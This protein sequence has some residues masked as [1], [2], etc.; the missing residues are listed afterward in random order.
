MRILQTI[1][2]LLLAPL[3]SW[4]QEKPKLLEK[5]EKKPGEIIIPYEK[6]QLPN[7]L[8][9]MVHEDHSNPMIHVEITY[10]VGS[11]REV[12]DRTG[13]AHFFEH[14]MFQGS[15]NVRDEEHFKIVSSAGG[16]MNGTT[17][18]D[19][20][21]YFET[22]PSNYLETAIWLEA[23]RMGF[24]LDSVTQKKF[25]VQRAT[26]KNEKGQ[27]VENRPYGM[28]EEIKNQ[29]LYPAGHPYSWTTIGYTEDLDRATVEDMRNFFLRW[30]GPNNAILVVSGDAKPEEVVK[31][32]EKY[33][34][35]IPKCPP[36]AKMKLDQV[37]LPE[38]VYAYY[39]DKIF[40]PVTLI[41]YPSAPAYHPDEPALDILAYIMGTG[42]SSFFYK[43]L[44]KTENALQA[45]A[46]NFS[47]ELAGEFGIQVAMFPPFQTVMLDS[48]N[49]WLNNAWADFEANG[50]T[51]EKL[52]MAKNSYESQFIN[53]MES[54]QSKAF[55]LTNW[56]LFANRSMNLNDEINRYRNVK[57]EDVMRVYNRYIKKKGAAWVTF[58][59]KGSDEGD[60][61]KASKTTDL[62]PVEIPNEYKNLSYRKPVDNF[63][64]SVHPTPG[65]AQTVVIPNI[66]EQ[67]FD[68]GIRIMGSQTT[69]VPT[70]TFLI[71]IK[72]GIGHEMK[73][74][75][76]AG[77]VSLFTSLMDEG[78]Q[79]K[80]A[81]QFSTELERLGSSINVSAGNDAV[82]VQVFSQLKNLDATLALLEEK[83]F[84][85]N[86]SN[87]DLKRIKKQIIESL[88]NQDGNSS[89][90]AEIIFDK[91]LF[92][93]N[94]LEGLN[95]TPKTIKNVTLEDIQKFYQDYFSPSVTE[96]CIAGDI[97][98][99]QALAKLAFLKKW[100]VKPVELPKPGEYF[101]TENTTIYFYDQ[102]ESPQSEI[103]VGCLGVPFN[104]TGNFLKANIMN[105]QLGGNFNS[106][107]N[108]NIRED[109][110]YTYGIR[111]GF[112]GDSHFGYFNI[113][114]GV[115]GEA[116]DSALTEIFK[117]L[118]NYRDNGVTNEEVEF[119][120]N[121]ML[122]SRSLR[123]ET[124]G[125]KVGY[126]YT[127][128]K[129]NLQPVYLKEQEEVISRISRDELNT[130]AKRLLPYEKMAVVIVGDKATLLKRVEA[131]KL[132]PVKNV[133]D[134]QNPP[135]NMKNRIKW[136]PNKD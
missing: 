109:K 59:P 112:N 25:E 133:K 4:A 26:V 23:D 86:F 96:I 36:V 69:E 20:T 68:N 58:L 131:L 62:T 43:H 134:Y 114:A 47:S 80:S 52:N 126:L 117:E 78:T 83:M 121:S 91:V 42:K 64:R 77:L 100:S 75:E 9:I 120:K 70:V 107:L 35:S 108:Q 45:T 76:K 99:E 28:F 103:R 129:Y 60:K 127:L 97:S 73:N 51:D 119:T 66:W 32:A 53:G 33:F 11:A 57:K 113:S 102:P 21:N 31:M 56:W 94:T 110:G 116:T 46:F 71:N 65:K 5:V 72:G 85:P 104:A 18:R 3:V 37:T 136:N 63:D 30:Y 130:I 17:N 122:N 39:N 135:L 10:H 49:V 115:K 2:F 90:I 48:V 105:F 50:L 93:N 118:K 92:G 89:Q 27:N 125:Q 19:R 22:L 98:Q 124:N 24:L 34:G 40:I 61:A 101:E 128:L 123:Y 44:E 81:E 6:W 7:G 15:N 88:K 132:G 13:F 67:K 106:R 12:K 41:T 74:P 84:K 1:T 38:N 79:S 95:P 87:D 82:T 16:Q 14:M 8:T 54:V 111:S 55:W 29:K